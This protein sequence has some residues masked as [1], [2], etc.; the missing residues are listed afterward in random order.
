MKS[1]QQI[2][3]KII[4]RRPI[5][6]KYVE[7][8]FNCILND[9]MPTETDMKRY[10]FILYYYPKELHDRTYAILNYHVAGVINPTLDRYYYHEV[11]KKIE[12]LCNERIPTCSKEHFYKLCEFLGDS[13]YVNSRKKIFEIN[14]DSPP[15]DT[16]IKNT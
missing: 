16:T 7:K 14:L 9:E 3:S 13:P 8:A 15:I 5:I 2:A 11:A 4:D 10:K 6:T 12:L 1:L